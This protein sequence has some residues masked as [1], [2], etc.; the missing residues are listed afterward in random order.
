M[1][2]LQTLEVRW[3]KSGQVK[4]RSKRQYQGVEM[5]LTQLRL[6]EHQHWWTLGF[7]ME[8]TRMHKVVHFE[9]IISQVISTYP[10][11]AFNTTSSQAY[12]GLLLEQ[13][14]VFHA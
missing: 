5:E 11:K 2:T 4:K 6:G 7:E 13:A 9:Q 8:E 14:S 10:E 1:E 3:F 12:P